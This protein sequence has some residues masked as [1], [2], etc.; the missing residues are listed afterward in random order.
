MVRPALW[1]PAEYRDRLLFPVEEVS[2][3]MERT[4]AVVS[5][6]RL[7]D[8]ASTAR[9]REDD[10]RTDLRGWARR[11]VNWQSW[12]QL[13]AFLH[14]DETGLRLDPSPY[15]KKGEVEEGEVKT[16]DRALEWLAGHNERHRDSIQ[17]IRS[18]RRWA[19]TAAYAE[20][21]TAKALPHADGTWRLHPSFGLGSDHDNRP[22]A[23]TGR[24]A[25]K[26]PPINQVPRSGD[27]PLGSLRSAFVAPAGCR[28]VVADFSQL[29]VV[30]LGHLCCALFGNGELVEFLRRGDDIHG[31][32]AKRAFERP[33]PVSAFKTEGHLKLLRF[34]AKAVVYGNNYG[35]VQ[36][37]TSVF[38]PS[39]EPLG[40]QRSDLLLG[41]LRGQFPEVPRYQGFV[42]DWIAERGSIISL[43]GRLVFLEG[44]RARR[45]G[46][47]NR[48]WRQALNYP[49]QAGG[50][51]IMALALIA[52]ARDPV[53]RD[54]G[55]VLSLVVHDEVVGWAPENNA[56]AA[57]ARV[58][59]LMTTQVE[60][61]APFGAEGHTGLNWSEAK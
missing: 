16:D 58:M 19:R 24:F 11:E 54:L 36:F 60:L 14:T 28:L 41:G 15:W 22:G 2:N 35:K 5:P 34:M 42:R 6:E 26:N 46:D 29:E 27:G 49:M 10:L 53:L 13:G 57:L 18:L 38:L 37:G 45:L 61:L 43:F 44:A 52:I 4:G 32:V 3:G 40:A 25:V 21:W 17:N 31:A 47:R 12:Q 50:Q 20:D 39:G 9:A 33:E 7:R 51:E 59:E 23:K 56:E 1:T 30:I 55:F 48:A 8:I